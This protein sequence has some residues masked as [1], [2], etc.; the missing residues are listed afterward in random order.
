[1]IAIARKRGA[2]G[3]VIDGAVR[4]AGSIAQAD[5]P[6]FARGAIHK[7][8]YKSGPGEINVSV[9]IG[10]LVVSPGDIVVGDEDGVVA[11]PQADAEELLRA[12]RAQ[13]AREA[14]IL[15]TI[16]E[17]RYRGAYAQVAKPTSGS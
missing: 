12:V 7:G 9:S 11:F 8:P 15:A 17:G 2:A 14:D 5:F 6:C 4:D 1:M 3:F 13:E 16:H 10:G